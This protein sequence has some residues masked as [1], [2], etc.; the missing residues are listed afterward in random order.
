MAC[1]DRF[2]CCV[3]SEV[4]H[5]DMAWSSITAETY[6]YPGDDAVKDTYLGLTGGADTGL[7][8]DDVL[9]T[10][11]AKGLGCSPNKIGPWAP[12]NPQNSTALRQCID[13]FGACRIGVNLP[14][15]AQQQFFN[16]EAWDLTGTEAD[17]DI[18][19]GHDVGLY[20]YESDNKTFYVVT[21]GKVQPVTLRWLY[22]YTTQARAVI[23]YEFEARGGDA[24]GLNITALDQWLNHLSGVAA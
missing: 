13:F 16:H 14:A 1:N 2:G 3:I 17:F 11:H 15:I 5:D 10:W 21:W 22:R 23:P 20:G 7:M 9:A 4:V 8:I 24:R 18:E 6:T 12:V 19:G